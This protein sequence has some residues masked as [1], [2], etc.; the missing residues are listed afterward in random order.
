MPDG[1][2]SL[3]ERRGYGGESPAMKVGTWMGRRRGRQ[4]VPR[5]P[6]EG[7]KGARQ[8]SIAIIMEGRLGPLALP[9][10]ATGDG[11]LA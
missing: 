7:G 3:K 11:C 9:G 1:T 10:A 4:R 2:V 5:Y 6:R 8:G